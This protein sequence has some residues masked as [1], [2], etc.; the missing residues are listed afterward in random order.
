MQV[1]M[2]IIYRAAY[3]RLEYASGFTEVHNETLC[4]FAHCIQHTH[5]ITYL[6]LNLSAS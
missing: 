4:R 1:S 3:G 6:S 5:K 2:P